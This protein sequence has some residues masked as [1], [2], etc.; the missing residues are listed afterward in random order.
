LVGPQ[1]GHPA[2]KKVG[3]WF[4][5]GYNFTGALRVLQ[6]QLSACTT[7]IILS[8]NKIQN[9]DIPVPA[10]PGPPAKWSLKRR[11]MPLLS[12]IQQYQSTEGIKGVIKF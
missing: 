1:E 11:E 10:N 4:V 8:S 7:S 12:V 6:L 9:R 5:G 3:C 2:C